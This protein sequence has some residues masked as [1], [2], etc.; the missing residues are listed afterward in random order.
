MASKPEGSSNQSPTEPFWLSEVTIADLVE[1]T[2]S[3]IGATARLTG[4]AESATHRRVVDGE[5]QY[6]TFAARL[7]IRELRSRGEG[8]GD[9]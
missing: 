1:V 2:A 4:V 8:R 5:V 3:R 9:A 7:M 6:S